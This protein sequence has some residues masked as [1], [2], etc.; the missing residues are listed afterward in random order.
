LPVNTIISGLTFRVFS[1]HVKWLHNEFRDWGYSGLITGFV[2]RI[3]RWDCGRID[4]MTAYNLRL[5]ST[6]VI[7]VICMGAELS[8]RHP[9]GL[10]SSW[11]EG[12]PALSWMR[13]PSSLVSVSCA[14]PEV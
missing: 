8:Q 9:R 12:Y 7:H 6:L 11:A 14:S 1:F 10:G 13:A 5:I 4:Q 2:V 3:Y